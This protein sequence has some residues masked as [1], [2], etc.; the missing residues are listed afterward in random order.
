MI[1][2]R[3]T[4]LKSIIEYKDKDIIKVIT[5][6]RRSG[7]SVL[8]FEIYYQYLIDIG[9]EKNHIIKVD[10][11]TQQNKVLRNAETLYTFITE[12][13][14][15][16]KK[17]YVFLDEIQFV[18]DFEDVVNGLRIDCN[19]DV[20]ITGSNSKL[21]SRDIHTRLRGR[22][23]EI[24][25][26]PLSFREFYEYAKGD[27]TKAYND[28]MLYGGLPYLCEQKEH[29]EKVEYLNMIC[30]TVVFK[31]IIDRY[32]IRDMAVFEA[33]F[34]F[35]CSNIGSIVSANKIANTLKSN[36]YKT[37]TVDTVNKYLMY[38][39]ESYLFYKV[40]RFDIKGKGYLKTL[41]K[42]Y[43]SDLGIRNSRLNYRQ[44]E[45][46][47]SLEN[48]MYLELLRRGYLVDIGK[49]KE[50]E[51]DFIAKNDKDTF[52][53]QVAYSII[54]PDKK[55]Q[56]LSSFYNIDDGYK[57]IVITMDNDPFT[58]LEKG[59]KKIHVFDFLLN[60]HSLEEL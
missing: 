29:K 49:N 13:I 26:Y 15:D 50:K 34:D 58:I 38:L 23:I 55:K 44:I 35:L 41:N 51:I 45:V 59:Y 31:D 57:K 22:S 14:M 53:I 43:I 6:I 46:T 48:I 16:E 12:R 5:G 27:I 39:C 30:D 54:D 9:I 52:Y 18:D 60:E 24:K 19:C 40:Y 42:Y 47:H 28:Y 21:L 36:G 11:E 2:E 8:L 17:Y 25:M 10:L 4:Y 1:I 3:P 20:Y 56:E 37:I 32:S 7:K 33:V